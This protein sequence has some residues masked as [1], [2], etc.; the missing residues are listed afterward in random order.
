MMVKQL[1]GTLL[2]ETRSGACFTIL[3]PLDQA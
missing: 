3:A 2:M 1:G